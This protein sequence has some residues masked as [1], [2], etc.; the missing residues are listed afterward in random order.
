[1]RPKNIDLLILLL[2][3]A[4]D[5]VWTL[6]PERP[7][8]LS[9]L[10]MLPLVFVLPGYAFAEAVFPRR[11]NVGEQLILAPKLQIERPLNNTDRILLSFGLSLALDIL[12]GFA[13]NLLPTGLNA[14]S[15]SIL[16]AMLTTLCALLAAYLRHTRQTPRANIARPSRCPMRF[17]EIALCL[18]AVIIIGV[19]VVYSTQ[20]ALVQQY[21]GFTQLWM[22]PSNLPKQ[23]CGIRLGIRSF[24]AATTAYRMTMTV[25][26]VGVNT[27]SGIVLDPQQEWDRFVPIT[28]VTSDA[29]SS[30]AVEV[31]L[32]DASKP[33][34]IYQKVNLTLQIVKGGSGSSGLQCATE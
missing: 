22:L 10:L 1:M 23:S 19:S 33:D 21:P 4:L 29:T 24:E 3:A 31:H 8:L 28:V 30:A 17:H 7:L 5:V 14:R 18:L 15:W 34:N 32:Y 13:L 16:L 2:I 26:G 12:S 9:V 20:G 27:W 25:N 11:T 6:L